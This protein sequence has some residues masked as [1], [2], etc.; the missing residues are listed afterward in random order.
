MLKPG[1]TWRAEYS[2]IAKEVGDQEN[3]A[4]VM[5]AGGLR[6]KASWK[7]R[8]HEPKLAVAVTGPRKALVNVPTK[9]EIAI[10]NKGAIALTGVELFDELPAGAAFV[11]ASDGGRLQDGR[12]H[13][14]LGQAPAGRNRSVTVEMKAAKEGE[15]VN[16]VTAKADRGVTASAEAKTLFAGAAGIHLQIDA[17]D[18]LAVGGE[19]DYV[20]HVMNHGSGAARNVQVIAVVPDQME[21]KSKEGPTEATVEKQTL[22]FAPLAALA[23]GEEKTYKIHVRAVRAGEVKLV[24]ELKS[25]ELN[26]PLHEEEPTTIFGEAAAVAQP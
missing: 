8:V 23:G 5:A 7:V 21:V 22:T 1:K 11:G 9:Y 6:E 19:S 12:I 25:D 17:K 4:Q 15:A 24:V 10:S 16:R 20:I 18:K 26:P 13:W 14:L 3:A 2:V